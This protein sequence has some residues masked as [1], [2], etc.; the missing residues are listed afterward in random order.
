MNKN[1]VDNTL[2]YSLIRAVIILLLLYPMALQFAVTHEQIH[3]QISKYFGCKNATIE[4]NWDTHGHSYCDWG[5]KIPPTEAIILHSWNE[6]VG[7]YLE[8]IIY[9]IFILAALLSI[10]WRKR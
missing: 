7:Y 3:Q 8:Y 1:L 6:I 2:V 4:I 9:I 5:E 10:K